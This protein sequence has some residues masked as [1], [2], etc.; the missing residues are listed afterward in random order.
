MFTSRLCIFLS[1]P[2]VL[3]T[4]T[5]TWSVRFHF[6][7]FLL[8]TLW[9]TELHVGPRLVPYLCAA[10]L[11]QEWNQSFG[12]PSTITSNCGLQFTSQLWASLCKLL[13][14]THVQTTVYL[15]QGNG[16][17][18]QLHCSRKDTLRAWSAG[19]SISMGDAGY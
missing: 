6:V 5:W 12:V 4:S 1:Q 15:P 7:Q 14:I 13:S 3:L 9:F 2:I 16:L 17:V 11:L 18:E 10:A 19:T 8:P